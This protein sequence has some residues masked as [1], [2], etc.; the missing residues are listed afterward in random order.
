LK[1]YKEKGLWKAVKT[2]DGYT[3]VREKITQKQYDAYM[4]AL[5]NKNND[6]E[7]I[8]KD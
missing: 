6:A 8:K 2:K 3:L 5:E 7:W 4:K 1:I